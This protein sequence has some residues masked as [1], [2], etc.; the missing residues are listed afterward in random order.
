M[1]NYT[2]DDLVAGVKRL[3]HLP[4]AQTT[5]QPTDILALADSAMRTVVSPKLAGVREGYWTT[6]KDYTI[7]SSSTPIDIAI[8]SLAL[9]SAIIDAKVLIGN[10]FLPVDRIEISELVSNQFTPRPNYGYWVEDNVLKFLTNG[11]VTGT[12]RLWYNRMASQLV[13]L[14]ACGQITVISGNDITVA[15]LPSTFQ[16]GV[17]LDI[18]SAT[19]GF[20]VLMKDT[21][22]TAIN[23]T[24]LTFAS[25]PSTAKVGDYVCLSGQACVVQ[26]PIEWISVLEQ[27]T[28]CK[29]YEAQSMFQKLAAADRTLDKMIASTL[30]LVSP[31]QIQKTKMIAAGG[32]LLGASRRKWPF[33]VG[34]K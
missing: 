28:V 34:N 4:G 13:Q 18:A 29:M 30:S 10:T 3:S 14:T 27:A 25:V 15:S 1:I 2:T 6:Y 5:F 19:P 22:P 16:L 8:P 23:N 9:G 12:L 24:T 26:C 11:G 33:A 32:Q 20:N 17:E 21:A 7:T 31:R